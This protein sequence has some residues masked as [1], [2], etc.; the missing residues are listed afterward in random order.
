M[1]D[2]GAGPAPYKKIINEAGLIYTSHDFEKYAPDSKIPG[3]Q[4]NEWPSFG[5]DLVCDINDL[6]IDKFD[7]ALCTEVL[8]HVPDPVQ[9]LYSVRKTLK[10]GG[11]LLITVPFASRMHQAPY[12]FSS[13]FSNFWFEHHAPLCGFTVNDITIAGDYIDQ[14]IAENQLF[15]GFLRKRRFNLEPYITKTIKRNSGWI[16][17]R[18]PKDLIQS[19]GLG[20]YA[21]L[22][23]I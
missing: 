4:S 5:H 10:I 6:P 15:F 14:M 13:G 2:I 21:S 17:A 19:G 22:T 18:L 16:R 9:A 23:A 7:L 12:Y 1:I 8:E 3:L 20:V 11:Q